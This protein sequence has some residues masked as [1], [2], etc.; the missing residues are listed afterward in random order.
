MGRAYI[1]VNAHTGKI[2]LIDKIIK[3]LSPNQNNTTGYSN[4]VPEVAFIMSGA[5]DAANVGLRV[6]VF[7]R[8]S[9]QLGEEV[10]FGHGLSF[11]GSGVFFPTGLPFPSRVI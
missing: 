10:V 9:I 4:L 11:F 1:Y 8:Q 2:M 5:A 3:H 7:A 6:G